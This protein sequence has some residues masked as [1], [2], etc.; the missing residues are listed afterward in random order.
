MCNGGVSL[1]TIRAAISHSPELKSL[2]GKALGTCTHSPMQSDLPPAIHLERERYWAKQSDDELDIKGVRISGRQG[3]LGRQMLRDRK[4]ALEI[5]KGLFVQVFFFLRHHS[6][7]HLSGNTIPWTWVILHRESAFLFL[8]G[9]INIPVSLAGSL[10]TFYRCGYWGFRTQGSHSFLR[11]ALSSA[12]GGPLLRLDLEP[13]VVTDDNST[14][15]TL[16]NNLC[17]MHRLQECVCS[18]YILD[19]KSSLASCYHTIQ[20]FYDGWCK[21]HDWY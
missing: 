6:I 3:C 15:E 13:A 9:I 5:F 18:V 4:Q 12:S 20:S 7:W 2:A 17:N 11:N 10:A 1:V 21:S 8:L 16:V 19:D 14:N